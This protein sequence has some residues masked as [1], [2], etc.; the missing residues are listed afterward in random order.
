M[1]TG[2]MPSSFATKAIFGL[3][4]ALVIVFVGMLVLTVLHP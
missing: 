4:A 1:T 2:Y 3:L